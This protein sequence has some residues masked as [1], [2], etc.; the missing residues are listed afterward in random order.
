M[1][2]LTSPRQLTLTHLSAPCP[3]APT[4]GINAG[5]LDLADFAP[6]DPEMEVCQYLTKE[7]QDEMT[8][9]ATALF[10]HSLK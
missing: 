8:Q 9:F 4:G 5:A 3:L 10:A 1:S 7:F 2:L 6:A